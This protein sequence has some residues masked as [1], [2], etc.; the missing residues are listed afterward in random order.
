MKYMY[1]S[2]KE[3][4]FANGISKVNQLA[5][6]GWRLISAVTRGGSYNFV[7]EKEVK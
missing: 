5:L 2:I 7:L 6:E 4:D 3:K 1:T